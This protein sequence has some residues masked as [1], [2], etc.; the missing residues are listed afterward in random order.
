MYSAV[1]DSTVH[2]SRLTTF[3]Y[4]RSPLHSCCSLP[5]SSPRLCEM[6]SCFSALTIWQR[7]DRMHTKTSCLHPVC[8]LF[9]CRAA[10]PGDTSTLSCASFGA[11]VRSGTKASIN[12]CARGGVNKSNVPIRGPVFRQS[13]GEI[14]KIY[15]NIR[16]YETKL[17]SQFPQYP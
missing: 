12:F 15:R 14:A 17:K 9:E 16:R 6:S 2:G 8:G 4:I 13:A 3:L 7:L 5:V 1:A 11:G 10:I